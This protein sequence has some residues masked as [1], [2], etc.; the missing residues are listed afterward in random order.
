[1]NNVSVT[2][3]YLRRRRFSSEFDAEMVGNTWSPVP[4]FPGSH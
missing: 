4:P 2:K 1:M 3:T